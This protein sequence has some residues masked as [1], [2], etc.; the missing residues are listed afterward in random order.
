MDT[1]EAASF[2]IAALILFGPGLVATI[3]GHKPKR[4]G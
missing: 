1:S 2:P 4:R 3:A